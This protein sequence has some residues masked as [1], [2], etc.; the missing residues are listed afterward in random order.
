MENANPIPEGTKVKLNVKQITSHPDWERL[1]D[2]YK[3]FVQD[4]ADAEFTVEYDER[5]KDNPVLVCLKE[6]TTPA[7]WLWW[8]GDLEVTK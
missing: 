5:H 1:Q 2:S 3:Q 8:V 4:N 7:K 6:D